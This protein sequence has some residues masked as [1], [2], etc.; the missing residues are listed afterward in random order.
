MNG[1]NISHTLREYFSHERE[2]DAKDITY[3][4]FDTNEPQG[5]LV[6]YVESSAWEKSIRITNVGEEWNG[7]EIKC[8]DI[9]GNH[10]A[11][12]GNTKYAQYRINFQGDKT[13]NL[14]LWKP[15]EGGRWRQVTSVT[16]QPG[17]RS[18]VEGKTFVVAWGNDGSSKYKPVDR[19][20]APYPN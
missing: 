16:V 6:L 19:I 8:G 10:H 3:R 1:Y 11:N 7:T 18:F 13:T 9:S 15:K 5:G 4:A 14:E 12:D 2:I 17:E 20:P